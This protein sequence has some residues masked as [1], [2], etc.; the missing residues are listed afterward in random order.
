MAISQALITAQ[1]FH[2][3]GGCWMDLSNISRLIS[4][5]GLYASA[6]P[7]VWLRFLFKELL[8]RVAGCF[9]TAV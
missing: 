7:K 3:D 5:L 8:T 9:K 6:L 1:K 2:I 4:F